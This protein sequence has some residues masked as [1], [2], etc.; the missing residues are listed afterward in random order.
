[1]QRHQFQRF[2]GGHGNAVAGRCPEFPDSPYFRS[3]AER[4]VYR[5]L[6][7]NKGWIVEHEK[8]R[9]PF[10]TPF[11]RAIDYLPDFEV[12]NYGSDRLS[13]IVE[14][15]GWLDGPSK[16]RLQG[17]KKHYPDLIKKLV[18]ITSAGKNEAWLREKIGCQVWI[19]S[20]LRSQVGGLV[21]WE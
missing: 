18:V 3:K 14:V 1:M 13:M 16:T 4:N 11:R 15:K 7:I 17:F 20:K 5:A 8:K 10:P 6:R 21:K 19:L 12:R 9:Y 2:K